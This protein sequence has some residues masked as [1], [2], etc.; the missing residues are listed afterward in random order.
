MG[1]TQTGAE[2]ECKNFGA[3]S[4]T[5]RNAHLNQ[6]RTSTR[7]GSPATVCHLLSLSSR[8]DRRPRHSCR[9]GVRVGGA[10]EKFS[11]G[12]S[13]G[14]AGGQGRLRP[15]VRRSRDP[16]LGSCDSIPLFYYR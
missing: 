1:A 13:G 14:G 9:R 15:L 3:M 7:S 2:R 11:D 16:G 10:G 4:W 8:C 12:V 6:T 5:L